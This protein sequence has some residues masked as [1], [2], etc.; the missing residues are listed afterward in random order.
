MNQRAVQG[1]RIVRVDHARWYNAH[2]RRMEI[3]VSKI[4]LEDGS[5]LVPFAFETVDTPGATIYHYPNPNKP[6]TTL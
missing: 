1:K 3:C 6:R 4:H 2:L 5:Y